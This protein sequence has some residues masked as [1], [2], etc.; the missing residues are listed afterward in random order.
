MTPQR[1]LV[2]GHTYTAPVNRLKLNFLA[3][4]PRFHILLLTPRRWR[5]SL[6][7]TD[8]ATPP[9]AHGYRTLFVEARFGPI[10]GWHHVLYLIPQLGAIIQDFQPHLIYCEQEPICLVA[11][12]TALLAGGIPL[13]FFSWENVQRRDLK[14][15]LLT[16]VR[17]WCYRQSA[18]MVAGSPGAAQVMRRQGYRRPIYI[19]PLLGVSEEMFYPAQAVGGPTPQGPFTIG[20]VGRF[21]DQKGV[22]TLLDAVSRMG[23]GIP[24]RLLLVGDGPCRQAYE[25]FVH[26][27]G[28]AGQV[29]FHAAVPHDRVPAFLRRLQV[30]VLPSKTTPTWKEQFGHVLIEAMACGVPVVGSSSGEIPATMGGAGLVFREGEARDLQRQLHTLYEDP[31]LREALSHRGLARVRDWFTDRKIAANTIAIFEK[32]LNLEPRAAHTLKVDPGC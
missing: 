32:A 25:A 8:N 9:Q 5:N 28:I 3:E 10:F 13:A 14:Y 22:D 27:E 7:V 31:G 30:L 6:T 26:R 21:A 19:T 24:W 29:E 2:I 17:A 12:Q 11:A 18:F 15:R 1:V 16:P 4:D 20:Y 23:P